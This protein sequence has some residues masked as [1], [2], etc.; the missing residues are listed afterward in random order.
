MIVV[1]EEVNSSEPEGT[2]VGQ[3]ISA[4]TRVA[5]KTTITLQVSNGVPATSKVNVKFNIPS[6]ATGR[7]IFSLYINGSLIKQV[8]LSMLHILPVL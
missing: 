7:F 6:D 8:M 4:G 5:A 2:V 3:S 1:V